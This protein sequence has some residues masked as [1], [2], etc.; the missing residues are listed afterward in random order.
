MTRSGWLADRA[1]ILPPMARRDRMPIEELARRTGVTVR[2][3]RAMQARSLLLPP[4]LVGRK[5][6]YTERHEARVRLVL[7]LQSRGF[8]LAAIQA[9]IEGWEQGSGL[10]EVMGLEDALMTPGT[11]NEPGEAD[12]RA[13]FPQLLRNPRALA[14]ALEQQLVVERDGR[15]VAPDPE[16]LDI[17]KQE[18]EAGFPLEAVL[19]D[20][21]A[22]LADLE[23]I[24]TRFRKSFFDHVVNPH[25]APG[26]DG[27][28]LPSV[29]AKVA[30]LRP[31]AV[32]LVT[33]LFARALERGGGADP[34]HG[35]AARTKALVGQAKSRV[36]KRT[37]GSG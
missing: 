8:S 26:D 7:K 1:R 6:F 2:N 33:I 21:D 35:R 24:A 30:L 32:R 37:R 14:K 20:G 28:A 18:V 5:G 22:L 31:A 25:L 34:R 3:L 12:V 15:V 17:V 9:L 29:A 4:E 27:S 19:N 23:R 16:L 10:L 36:T 13:T 11:A